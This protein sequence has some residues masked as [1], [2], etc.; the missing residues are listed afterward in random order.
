MCEQLHL[1]VEPG[2]TSR[3]A[4]SA[5]QWLKQIQDVGGL[6]LNLHEYTDDSAQE[7]SSGVLDLWLGAGLE[8]LRQTASHP[9]LPALWQDELLIWLRAG[10]QVGLERWPQLNG[11]RG[12]FWPEQ[13]AQGELKGLQSHLELALLREFENPAATLDAL[14]KGEIDFLLAEPG[15]IDGLLLQPLSESDIEH[16]TQPLLVRPRYLAIS[17]KTAC[18]SAT[19]IERLAAALKN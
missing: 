7:F 6:Q 19:L 11:L 18:K 17:N 10:E 13:Q 12:G 1:V 3:D 15:L 9:V 5:E 4:L 2:L 16:L 8:R 14:L